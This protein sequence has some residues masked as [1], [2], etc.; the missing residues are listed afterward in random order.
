MEPL[1]GYLTPAQTAAIF[2]VTPATVRYWCRRRY[3]DSLT[4][5]GRVFIP[6]TAVYTLNEPP[7][8]LSKPFLTITEA[9]RILQINRTALFK[10]CYTGK[11]PTTRS[12][13]QYRI[14]RCTVQDLMFQLQ[15]GYQWD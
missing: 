8:L 14:A 1:D 11:I 4:L 2:G 7:F 15:E 6:Q 10:W 9:A 3:L 13:R 5:D 12:G